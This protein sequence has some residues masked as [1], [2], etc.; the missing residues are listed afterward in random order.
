M[1]GKQFR[2]VELTR[3]LCLLSFLAATSSSLFAQDF[4]VR[5]QTFEIQE[6]D[7]LQ[8]IEAKL[9]QAEQSG[10]LKVIQ[11]EISKR[12]QRS[13]ERPNPVVGVSRT[14]EAKR[15]FY[16]PTLVVEE[17]V[18]DHQG[19]LVARKGT[20]INPLDYVSWGTP[21]LLIDAD[22]QEQ[23]QWATSFADSL[24]L[25]K[26]APLALEKDLNRP[27]FFDQGSRI[28]RKFGISQVPCRISQAGRL[29]LVE[30]LEPVTQQRRQSS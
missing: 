25:V 23:V 10:S 20:R 1:G 5:G 29:L 15:Y 12:V 9:R 18:K 8:V 7:L 14:Q 6:N 19:N 2:F 13:I 16:D 30:E 24:V 27:I 4:G 3:I 26:G 17:D 28:V 22:D 21:L 11:E